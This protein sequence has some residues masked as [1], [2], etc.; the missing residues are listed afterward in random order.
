MPPLPL[1][2]LERQPGDVALQVVAPVVVRAGKRLGV[3]GIAL[4]ESD[5]AMRA[6]I[7]ESVDTAVGVA[8]DDDRHVPDKAAL[9]V[10]GVRDLAFK[11]YV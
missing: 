2:P 6:A 11:C 9:V 8:H 7:G 4:A 1:Y 10:A 5:A 3:T